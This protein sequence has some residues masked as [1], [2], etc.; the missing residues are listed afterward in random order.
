M[1]TE[2]ELFKERAEVRSDPLL[3]PSLKCHIGSPKA[4][5]AHLSNQR[6]LV[7]Q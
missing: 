6:C 3:R 7:K 2:I 5:Q 4:L 1:D